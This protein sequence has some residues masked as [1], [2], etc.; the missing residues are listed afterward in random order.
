MQAVAGAGA[1]A[2]PASAQLVPRLQRAL[3]AVPGGL[4]TLVLLGVSLVFLGILSRMCLADYRNSPLWQVGP[5]LPYLPSASQLQTLRAGECAPGQASPLHV[6]CPGLDPSPGPLPGLCLELAPAACA[7]PCFTPWPL[8]VE[9]EHAASLTAAERKQAQ[10]AYELQRA[11]LDFCKLRFVWSA[12][13]LTLLEQVAVIFLGMFSS[14]P[15]AIW[16]AQLDQA[17]GMLLAVPLLVF[18]PIVM[19]TFRAKVRAQAA[20]AVQPAGEQE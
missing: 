6:P 2:G 13:A 4:P 17:F 11:Y 8:Q 18:A 15:K 1:A 16:M 3:A 5:R 14:Q 10:V 12:V 20:A 19:Q 9:L 7:R